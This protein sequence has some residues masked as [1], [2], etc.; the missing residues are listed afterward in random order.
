[1]KPYNFSVGNTNNDED[2]NKVVNSDIHI[3]E[4]SIIANAANKAIS[5]FKIE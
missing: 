3:S 1:M 4:L 2:A 5:S